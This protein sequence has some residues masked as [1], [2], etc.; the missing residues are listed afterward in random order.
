MKKPI[1]VQ[2][3]FLKDLNFLTDPTEP[4]MDIVRTMQIPI[5]DQKKLKK[6]VNVRES[7]LFI[8][9]FILACA[10]ALCGCL[11]LFIVLHR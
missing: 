3:K 9:L 1:S 10:L 11:F 2:F 4:R 7:P 6:R 5:Q 8:S